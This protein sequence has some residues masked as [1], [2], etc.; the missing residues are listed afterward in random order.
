MTDP[1]PSQPADVLV[2]VPLGPLEEIL[3]HFA[4]SGWSR[5]DKPSLGQAWDEVTAARDTAIGHAAAHHELHAKL[6][7]SPAEPPMPPGEYARVEIMG[8]DQVTG[9]VSDG[10]RAG[11]PVMV[12]RGFDGRVMRE[13]PG[14]ALY[15][16]FPLPTPL[17]RPEPV[18]DAPALPAGAH[19]ADPQ[20]TMALP[21]LDEQPIEG[22]CSPWAIDLDDEVPA[23]TFPGREITRP[24]GA[25]SG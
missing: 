25:V 13:V 20:A 19:H 10:T 4:A 1:T 8:H 16:Y 14:H 23:D 22:Y 7:A 24:D 21:G 17:R 12:V 15:Q 2:P 3:S 18:H 9:W 6:A 5:T 11:V